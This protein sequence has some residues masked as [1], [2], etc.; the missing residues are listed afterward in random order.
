MSE[1]IRNK[2]V[3]ESITETTKLLQYREINGQ[4]RLFG[5]R[6]MEWIDEVAALTAMRHCGGLVT[7]CAVDNLRFKY[8]AYI[9]EIIVLIGKITYVG[10]TSMEVRV[11]TYVEDIE[12]GIRRAINHAYLICVHVDEDGKPI[13]VKY[14]LEV[15]TLSEQAE[16]EGAIKRNAVR[17]QRTNDGY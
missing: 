17:K 6:L 1:K 13:P 5:G 15:K 16:W 3:E 14:G 8:G 7:T 9:N 2:K 4:N 12:T 11:D 10:N